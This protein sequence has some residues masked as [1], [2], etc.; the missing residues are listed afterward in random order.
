MYK[1]QGAK[2][3]WHTVDAASGKEDN[4][5]YQGALFTLSAA[6]PLELTVT[7]SSS[8]AGGEVRFTLFDR[9][10]GA[11]IHSSTDLDI[12]IVGSTASATQVFEPMT[13]PAGDYQMHVIRVALPPMTMKWSYTLREWR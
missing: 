1:R 8:P 6:T 2:E 9:K 5:D 10:K 7:V 3:A 11:A 13:M 4:S 12:T